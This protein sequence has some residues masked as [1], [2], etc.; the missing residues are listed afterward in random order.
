MHLPGRAVRTVSLLNLWSRNAGHRTG[1][2]RPALHQ[3]CR[4]IVAVAG[5]LLVRA[6]WGHPVAPVIED[7]A[8]IV[9][10]AVGDDVAR[11]GLSVEVRLRGANELRLQAGFVEPA[12]VSVATSENATALSGIGR[13]RR[14]RRNPRA[15]AAGR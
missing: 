7:A 13:L 4:D 12:E 5:A 9:G 11:P 10:A 8:G 14:L 3:G 15:A 2:L 1:V 6:Q